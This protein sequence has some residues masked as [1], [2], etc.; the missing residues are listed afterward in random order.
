[1]SRTQAIK[2]GYTHE[3][4]IESVPCWMKFDRDDMPCDIVGK[5]V[6]YDWLL[7]HGVV[8]VIQSCRSF[9][10][11]LLT[12]QPEEATCCFQIRKRPIQ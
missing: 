7:D 4:D 3:G 11:S 1:M 12:N 10:A 5:N 6:F 2:A 8:Q 9:I